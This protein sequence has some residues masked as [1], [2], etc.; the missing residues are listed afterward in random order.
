[1]I[2]QYYK[3][4]RVRDYMENEG[5]SKEL[6]NK[7]I[8]CSL[9]TNPFIDENIIR[10]YVQEGTTEINKYPINGYNRLTEELLKYWRYDNDIAVD[11]NK[12]NIAFG[13]G[14]MGILRN[15]SQF[16][17]EKGSFVLGYSPQF[18]RFV[19]EVELKKGIYEYYNL[20]KE[21]NY[22]FDAKKFTEKINGKYSM[23]YIDNPNNPTGQII[24]VEDIEYIVKKAKKWDITVVVDEAYG[25]YMELE[26]SSIKLIR[27]YDNIVVLRSASKYFGLPNHR[28]GYLFAAEKFIKVY[29]M[30]T[31]PF[32]FPDLSANIFAS[33]LND[34]KKIKGMKEKVVETN[35]KI[36]QSLSTENYLYTN[37]ETPI[38]TVR[39]SKYK[40]LTNELMKRG[41]ISESC[42]NFINLD[43]TYTRIRITKEYDRLIKI[44]NQVL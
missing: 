19:S 22:K 9:G 17:I 10:Q 20:Q 26:N 14:T 3:E 37:L 41:I 39:S 33:I 40:N 27:K 16:L 7:S 1:M 2:D 29:N 15:I 11:I 5:I 34:Y 13:A 35:K 4:F 8:D 44:L 32:S 38:F 23:I 18:P 24:D 21:N 28:I 42:S 36:Y 43:D 12:N 6:Y 31:I 30:I 25:D